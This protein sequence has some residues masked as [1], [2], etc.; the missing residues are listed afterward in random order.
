MSAAEQDSQRIEPVCDG[1]LANWEDI[2]DAENW[3][4]L[5][6]GNG[7]SVHLWDKFGYTSLYEAVCDSLLTPADKQL[8]ELAGT[9]NFE[10]VLGDLELSIKICRSSGLDPAPIVA[11]YESI[12][13]ALAG[14]VRQVHIGREEVPAEA[15]H[16]IK[17]EMIEHDWVFSLNYD[18]LL[19]WAMGH[20]LDGQSDYGPLRD[21]FFAN[22]HHEFGYIKDVP[23]SETPVYFLH[24]ALHLVEVKE[25]KSA[26]KIVREAADVG[27][28]LTKIGADGT[29][30]LIVTEGRPL[31]KVETI[32]SNLYLSHAWEKLRQRDEGIVIFG[33]SLGPSDQHLVD[34]I[35]EN[36][37]RA[38][39]IS[40]RPKRKSELMIRQ[41]RLGEIL[42]VDRLYFYEAETHPLGGKDL[43]ATG[44]PFMRML[45]S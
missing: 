29:L 15:M 5:L 44:S 42:H 1:T 13:S 16:V 26:R 14:A 21:Y 18:M 23:A 40:M 22:G 38:V 24:G 9:Q 28:L 34:A 8:F 17:S 32:N 35:N 10:R 11:R 19:Y 4:T 3:D 7:L 20:A 2:C 27:T 41:A 43:Q 12:K 6:V 33:S 45:R 39:A 25:S 36:R 30:P 31:D 37:E